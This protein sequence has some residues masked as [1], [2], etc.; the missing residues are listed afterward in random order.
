KN[1]AVSTK[2]TIRL[3]DDPLQAKERLELRPPSKAWYLVLSR[4]G[5]TLVSWCEDRT[6]IQWQISD[7]TKLHTITLPNRPATMVIA[8]DSRHVIA[9]TATGTIYIY[10]LP[11]L[12][13]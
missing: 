8:R 1:L 12:P 10:R 7:G 11:P 13:G 9:A 6:M 4:D 5:R 2:G 3:W